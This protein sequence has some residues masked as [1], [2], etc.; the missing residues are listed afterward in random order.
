MFGTIHRSSSAIHFSTVTTKTLNKSHK[1]HWKL[2]N[3][4]FNEKASEI[5]SIGSFWYQWS[6]DSRTFLG[7]DLFV[8][9]LCVDKDSTF[10]CSTD[11]NGYN[12]TETWNTPGDADSQPRRV[13]LPSYSQEVQIQSFSR[14]IHCRNTDQP[15]SGS[16]GLFSARNDYALIY[17]CRG[18]YR[19]TLLDLQQLVTTDLPTQFMAHF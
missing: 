4:W 15:R 7:K 9:V 16:L 3:D 17:M 18:N 10:E 14:W 12:K 1:S 6:N 8:D 5:L 11:N 2:Q 19:I 13:W